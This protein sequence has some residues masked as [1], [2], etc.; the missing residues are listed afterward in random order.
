MTLACAKDS[1]PSVS[2][3]LVGQERGRSS[4]RC[5]Q[6]GGDPPQPRPTS[7]EQAEKPSG[8][9]PAGA[10]GNAPLLSISAG[11]NSTWGSRCER[12]TQE[13]FVGGKRV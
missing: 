3:P 5:S 7:C 6:G 9:G 10:E 2:E 8:A 11:V 4:T 13:P 1:T 12:E